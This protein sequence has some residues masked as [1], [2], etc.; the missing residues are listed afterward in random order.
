VT[1]ILGHKSLRGNLPG[2]AFWELLGVG[3]F[4]D[5]DLVDIAITKAN[6]SHGVL[7]GLS[8]VVD[9]IVAHKQLHFSSYDDLKVRDPIIR[10]VTTSKV[11]F[12]DLENG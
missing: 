9:S 7:E 6:L 4:P 11:V 3:T 8:K 10:E 5:L 12:E 2:A 1:V